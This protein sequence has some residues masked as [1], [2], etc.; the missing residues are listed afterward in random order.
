[1]LNFKGNADTTFPAYAGS[2]GERYSFR[3]SCSEGQD[4]RYIC[5]SLMRV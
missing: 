2:V 5:I 1:M 3:D 4:Y